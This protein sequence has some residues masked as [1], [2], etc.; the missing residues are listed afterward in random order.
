[1]RAPGTFDEAVQIAE[2][3]DSLRFSSQQSAGR[4][5]GDRSRPSDGS[6]PME[7]DALTEARPRWG[8]LYKGSNSPPRSSSTGGSS[9]LNGKL[10]PELRQKLI[11]EGRCFYCRETGH[12]ALA[13]PKRK[14]PSK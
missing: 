3:F 10:T 14:Q 13:C 11:K 5:F 12:R 2:R 7:L 4:F 1:M 8:S 9:G 6:S